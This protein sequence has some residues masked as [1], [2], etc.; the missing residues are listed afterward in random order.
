MNNDLISREWLRKW[1]KDVCDCFEEAAE[2]EGYVVLAM[3][4]EAPAVDAVEVVRCRDCIHSEPHNCPGL[5]DEALRYCLRFD[6][7][8]SECGFCHKGAKMD[9]E[10]E[11]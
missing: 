5:E 10:V 1:A 4:E 9:A 11:G 2:V 8:V 7:L 6:T 3:P